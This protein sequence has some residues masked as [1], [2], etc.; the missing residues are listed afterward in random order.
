MGIAKQRVAKGLA[1]F[2]RVAKA[3]NREQPTIAGDFDVGFIG[4]PVLA[5]KD[6]YPGH[7]IVAYDADFA[8]PPAGHGG[9]HRSDTR[10][11]K[12]HILDRL[13]RDFQSVLYAQFDVMH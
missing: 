11:W 8:L 6:C 5:E 12:I 2:N 3:F 10:L 9:D 13:I 1:F 4:R 7:A